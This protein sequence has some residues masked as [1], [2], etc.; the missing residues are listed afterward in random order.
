MKKLCEKQPILATAIFS[1]IL[2]AIYT[3]LF[4]VLEVKLW[5]YILIDILIVPFSWLN[6][7]SIRLKPVNSA[8]I[9]LN[10]KCDPYPL[11]EV[12]ERR[13][14]GEKGNMTLKINLACGY[15]N[16]GEFEK[17][18][19]INNELADIIESFSAVLRT[20]YY[21]NFSLLSLETGDTTKALELLER[22]E[23]AHKTLG[24]RGKRFNSML[25][26]S[27]AEILVRQ[28][29]YDEAEKLL[30]GTNINEKITQNMVFASLLRARIYASR[31]DT[32][33]ASEMLQYVMHNGNALFCAKTAYELSKELSN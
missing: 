3:I 25:C 20:V 11:I 6:V 10:N 27:R 13:L 33:K 14:E 17:S 32:Q 29:N 26:A 9:E 1:L 7:C 28:G 19:A 12:C 8:I 31:G 5:A 24:K 15:Y 23:E 18:L 22:A 16:A 21:N 30:E 2:I 4:L